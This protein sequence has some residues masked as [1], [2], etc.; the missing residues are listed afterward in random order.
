M[1]QIFA[2]GNLTQDAKVFNYGD[3]RT[4]VSFNIASN[5]QFNNNVEYLQCTCFNRGEKLASCLR[6]GDQVIVHGR[7]SKNSEGYVSC[8]V[9]SLEFGRKKNRNIQNDDS[10]GNGDYS[11]SYENSSYEGYGK[12]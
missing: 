9:D 10:Y 5:D 4:G 11:R 3:N 2:N 1:I 6:Q 8:I 12:Y 7:Y